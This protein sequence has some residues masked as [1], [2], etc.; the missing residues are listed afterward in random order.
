MA[1]RTVGPGGLLGIPTWVVVCLGL[2]FLLGGIF[3]QLPKSGPPAT[4]IKKILG[5][6]MFISAS[7]PIWWFMLCSSLPLFIRLFFAV[8]YILMVPL[9]IWSYLLWRREKAAIAKQ[10]LPTGESAISERHKW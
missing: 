1:T 9:A 5:L 10:A 2:P 7:A 8:P 3:V 4:P 6:L